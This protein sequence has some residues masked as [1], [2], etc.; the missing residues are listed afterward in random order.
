M[1]V[2][3]YEIGEEIARGSFGCILKGI[4]M[5]KQE[6]VAIKIEYGDMKSLKHE[7]KIMNFLSMAGV[8]KIPSIYWYGIHNENPCLIFTLYECSLFDYMKNKVITVEKMNVLMIKAI[9]IIGHIH[10]K[11][12]L[13]RD[14]K[15]QN[16]MIKGGDI[17]L[18]D[19]GLAT[20]YIDETGEHYPDKMS[21]SII[22]TPKFVSINVHMGHRYSRR[23]DM[24]SLGYMY[25]Y[26]ILGSAPWLEANISI[27]NE[28]G[29]EGGNENDKIKDPCHINYYMNQMLQRNKQY[30]MFSKYTKDIICI[31]RYI[32]YMY[33]LNY[34]D[35]PKYTP[36]TTLFF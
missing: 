14:I 24:I 22:G 4:Y 32:Q 27:N 6:P 12:V 31:D 9:D 26:M 20:F 16:F 19:F 35:K 28:G 17:F 18:I 33:A 13:H 7:V 8:K 3:K 29:N 11:M 15:P 30:D 2:N 21:D 25:V 5:K 10:E 23:D 34:L 36:L 1:I